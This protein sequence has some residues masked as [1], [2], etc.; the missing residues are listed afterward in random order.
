MNPRAGRT[1]NLIFAFLAF[2][3]YFNLLVLGK[4]WIENGQI[5]MLT[6]LVAL[7]GGT[8]AL[9]LLWL[10]K[11]HHSWTFFGRRRAVAPKDSV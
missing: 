10:A 1:G 3:V 5:H 4:S 6:Y 11:R 9:G 8:L 2:V 7:H